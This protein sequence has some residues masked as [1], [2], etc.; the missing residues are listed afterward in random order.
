MI[1]IK[2]IKGF[3]NPKEIRELNILLIVLLVVFSAV[4]SF[5]LYDSAHSQ[6]QPKLTESSVKKNGYVWGV[7][8]NAYFGNTMG[9]GFI[10]EHTDWQI[11]LFKDLGINTVKFNLLFNRA[12]AQPILP[13]NDYYVDKLIE[14]HIDRYMVIENGEDDDFFETANYSM[15]YEW[16][17]YIASHFA[18]KINYYQ[19]LNE[20]SGTAMKPQFPGFRPDDY[21]EKKYQALKNYLKGMSDAIA[22]FDPG[23]QRVVTAHFLGT[24]MIDRLIKDGVNFEVIGWDWYSDMGDSLTKKYHGDQVFNIP[25]HFQFSGKKFWI[26]ELNRSHGSFENKEVEQSQ[27][28]K[29]IIDEAVQSKLVQG[30]FVF[31]MFDSTSAYHGIP[32]NNNTW[33]LITN[34]QDP[35]TKDWFFDS[36][37]PAYYMYQAIIRSHPSI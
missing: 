18:G 32:D 13:E 8:S 37:K 33:G 24:A 20:V 12:L 14:N 34:K 4:F 31:M 35:V 19:M 5:I 36:K 2:K 3:F 21:D 15:G 26:S 10:K 25:Q 23:A 6:D 11:P 1:F 9:E 22:Q 17:K 30:I 28:I 16:G 7:Y 29:K 27:Y